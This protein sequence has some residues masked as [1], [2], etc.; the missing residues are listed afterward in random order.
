MQFEDFMTLFVFLKIGQWGN[1]VK[2]K[3]VM[4]YMRHSEINGG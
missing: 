4:F 3:F 2:I 1:F